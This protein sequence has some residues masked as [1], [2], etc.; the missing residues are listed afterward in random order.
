MCR[1]HKMCRSLSRDIPKS[2]FSFLVGIRISQ[3]Q[4]KLGWHWNDFSA[5][6]L[7]L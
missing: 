6:R 4:K 7:V 3:K 1:M 2:I 5:D